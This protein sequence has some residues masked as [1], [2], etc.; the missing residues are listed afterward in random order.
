MLTF[1]TLLLLFLMCACAYGCQQASPERHSPG[2]LGFV[3]LPSHSLF[4][5]LG[6]VDSAQ[7]TSQQD[8]EICLSP[9]RLCWDLQVCATVPGFF[10]MGSGAATLVPMLVWQARLLPRGLHCPIYYISGL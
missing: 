8:P 4:A 6:L 7:L 5:D 9:L 10:F 3:C 2:D 1:L